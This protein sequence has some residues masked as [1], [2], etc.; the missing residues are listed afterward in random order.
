LRNPLRK[1]CT[2][3]SVR[4]ENSVLPWWTYTRT[5]LETVDSAKESLKQTA[6]FSTRR[7]KPLVFAADAVRYGI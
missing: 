2:V 1:I 4:G 3:G 5:K 6:F 7:R